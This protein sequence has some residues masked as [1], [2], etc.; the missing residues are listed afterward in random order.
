MTVQKYPAFDFK[1]TLADEIPKEKP[2]FV[3]VGQLFCLVQVSFLI[4]Y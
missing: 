4:K 1:T 3:K 2:S